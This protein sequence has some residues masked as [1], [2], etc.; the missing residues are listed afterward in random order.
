MLGEGVN[1]ALV[2]SGWSP[3]RAFG[4]V[5]RDGDRGLPE[6]RCETEALSQQER[7]ADPVDQ[8][9]QVHRFLPRNQIAI[10]DDLLGHT[11]HASIA[12]ADVAVG[13]IGAT[14]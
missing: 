14:H 8:L 6:V 5:R 10:A 13:E 1:Q 3:S 2:I 9:C 7:R 12:R 11:P 4:D